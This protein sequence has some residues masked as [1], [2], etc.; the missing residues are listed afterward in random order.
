MSKYDDINYQTYKERIQNELP[1]YQKEKNDGAD[2][3]TIKKKIEV[4]EEKYQR[5][6]D[7]MK[8]KGGYLQNQDMGNDLNN[9]IINSIKGKLAIIE[10]LNS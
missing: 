1:H 8:V 7:L 9:I 3:D 2:F 6:K 5:E 4:L 10:N